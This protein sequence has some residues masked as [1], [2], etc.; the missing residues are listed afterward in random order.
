EVLDLARIEAGHMPLTPEPIRV[1]DVIAEVLDLIHPL[2]E[3]RAI[4]L[5]GQTATAPDVYV[6]AD[7]QRLKQVLLNLVSNAVKY[8]H[9]KGNVTLTVEEF[10]PGRVHLRVHD[11]GPGLT[12]EQRERLFNPFDRLGAEATGVEGT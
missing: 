4:R 11:T 6:L 2:A 5:T 12:P 7:E 1:R 10:P 8:N 9:E 3:R